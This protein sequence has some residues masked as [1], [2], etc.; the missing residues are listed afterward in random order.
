MVELRHVRSLT[1]AAPS[2]AG[3][4]AHV[5]AASGLVR[6]GD[7]LYVV[8]DD[9]NHLAVFPASGDAPGSLK[10]VLV[11]TLPL[12][13]EERKRNKADVEC[14]TRLPAFEGYPHGALLMLGSCSTRSRCS[15]VLLG[16][17]PAGG[18]DGKRLEVDLS[19]LHDALGER[20]AR[21]NIEGAL[22]LGEDLV[23]L[24]RGNRSDPRNAR[25]RLQLAAA[26]ASL[27]SRRRLG[28]E[29]LLRVEPVALG[30]AGDIPFCFT[31][32]AALAGGRMIFTAVAEDTVDGYQDGVCGGAAIG[33]LAADGRIERLEAID[34]RHKVEGVEASEEGGRIRALLVTDA[35]DAD[36]PA[37]LLECELAA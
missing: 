7:R 32:G 12:G 23:L 15:G 31:D 35:D 28:A 27:V 17:E 26:I 16:L 22:P 8:A 18:L 10:Q 5:S 25:I 2:R 6:A 11:G 37:A 36:V 34:R 3:R 24:Q 19:P 14:I 20:F 30:S 4:P 13:K 21:V 29:A 33:I 9:E 1:L